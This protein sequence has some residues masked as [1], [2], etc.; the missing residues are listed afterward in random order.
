IGAD[1]VRAHVGAVLQSPSILNDSVRANLAFGLE[2]R[3]EDLWWALRVAQLDETIA[4]LERGLDAVLGNRGVR[5]SGGQRQ[6]LAIARM[7]LTD[8]K[9]VILDEATSAVDI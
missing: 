3:D 8:P 7:V 1:R 4:R 2:R 5:L 9:I 6:R